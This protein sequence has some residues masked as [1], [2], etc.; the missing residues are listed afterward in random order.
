MLSV[1]VSSRP[2]KFDFNGGAFIL[3]T[4]DPVI[5]ETENGLGFGTVAIPPRQIE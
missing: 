5:V 4:G 1:F 3:K 2:G